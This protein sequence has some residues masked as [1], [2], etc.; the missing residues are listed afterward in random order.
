MIFKEIQNFEHYKINEKGEILNKCNKILKNYLNKQG[1]L[2]VQLFKNGTGKT[3]FVHRLVAISFVDNPH[4]YPCV[5]HLDND[6]MNCNAK[7]LQWG[8]Q[9]QNLESSNKRQFRGRLS[10][11]RVV[12]MFKS[13]KWESANEFLRSII[14]M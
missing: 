13:K 6:K 14:A 3:F 4:N 7:N 1:Y 2:C 11:R 5:M 9:K 8:T 12:Q 10:K